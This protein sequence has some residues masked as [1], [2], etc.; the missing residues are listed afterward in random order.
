MGTMLAALLRLQSIERQV[1][2]V[3]GRL[4]TRQNAVNGQQKRID[5]L[6]ADFDA[7]HL[8]SQQRQKDADALNLEVRAGD[9]KVAK[10]RAALNLAK[11]NKE[12]A[13]VLTQINT[14][15]ADNAKQEEGVLKILQ[16]V[17]SIKAEGEKLKGQMDAEAKRL[18]DIVR[19]NNTE[20][21]KLNA[22]LAELTTQRAEAA[23]GVP[24]EP[25]AVFER[26][27]SN[28]DGEGMAVVEVQGKRP[29][30]DYICGG[31]Y[32]SLSPEHANALKVRDEIRTCNNCGRILY[33]EKTDG[34]K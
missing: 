2:Q 20:I 5:Q 15:K 17:E 34:S 11:T 22:M 21:Q 18:E 9:E 29:P 10:S 13:A 33:M 26:V 16:E 6:K 28:Y 4:R 7:L 30:F 8:K 25:L 14:I 31:C 1:A 24:P 3:R 27:A 19:N 12:Y 23:K 32:M